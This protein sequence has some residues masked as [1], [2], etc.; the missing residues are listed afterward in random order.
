MTTTTS[1]IV[2]AGFEIP[3]AL[4][5]VVSLIG[6]V[7]GILLL[8]VTFIAAAVVLPFALLLTFVLGRGHKGQR[9]GWQPVPV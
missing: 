6:L 2:L 7:T 5:S 8:G 4:R 3:P 9:K 1:E